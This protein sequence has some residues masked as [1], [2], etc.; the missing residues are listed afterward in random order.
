MGLFGSLFSNK[1]SS[2]TSSQTKTNDNKNLLEDG[3]YAVSGENNTLVTES[4]E[5]LALADRAI[6]RGLAFV[7]DNV[8]RTFESV[9]EILTANRDVVQ[10]AT[11]NAKETM[12]FVQERSQADLPKLVNDLLPWLLGAL[13]LYFAP[14]ILNAMK[15]LF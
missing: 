10:N 1:S 7:S 2:S 13:G 9:D 11:N 14:R 6:E 8:N 12:Q 3:G 5:A 15:G 4:P